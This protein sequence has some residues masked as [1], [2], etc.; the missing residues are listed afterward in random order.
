MAC[1]FGLFVRWL[2]EDMPSGVIIMIIRTHVCIYFYQKYRSLFV[3]SRPAG[4]LA[5]TQL[6]ALLHVLAVTCFER[7]EPFLASPCLLLLHL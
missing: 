5:D 1:L 7:S 3:Q 4:I 6:T 2:R